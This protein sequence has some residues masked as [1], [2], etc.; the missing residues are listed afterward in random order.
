MNIVRYGMKFFVSLHFQNEY[1]YENLRQ[2]EDK[3]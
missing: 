2:T 1:S 3:P